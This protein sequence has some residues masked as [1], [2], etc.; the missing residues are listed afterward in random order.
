LAISFHHFAQ[1]LEG[2]LAISVLGDI[3]LEN[4][5]CGLRIGEAAKAA[6]RSEH[7]RSG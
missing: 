6:F 5:A 3:G 7:P 2:C 1:K 4:F